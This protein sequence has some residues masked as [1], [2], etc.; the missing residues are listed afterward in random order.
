MKINVE[1]NDNTKIY[2][3]TH[4]DFECPVSND[5]YEIVDTRHLFKEDK[6]ENG[7]DGLFYSELLTYHYLA[8]HYETIPEYV[9]FCHYR[10]YFCFMDDVP[11]LEKI[12]REHGCI[13]TS[14]YYLGMDVEQQY[15]QCF[16]YADMD[17]MKAIIRCRY[18]QLWKSFSEMLHS[19]HLYIANMFI[20]RRDDFMEIMR[21][22]WDALNL[23][24]DIMGKDLRGHIISHSEQYLKRYGRGASIEHQYRIGGNL[25]E[26]IVSAFI[27]DRFPN[28]K[29][30]DIVF[31][32]EARPHRKLLT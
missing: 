7:M 18:P 12:I 17:V 28:C 8:E 16:C 10:K 6:A 29:T 3:C 20:M 22:V 24:L 13:A 21:I 15:A 25:G 11:D 32:E 14:P 1:M 19:N 31:T 9:G 2:I 26:R 27:S 4:T 5:V 23:W 30:Y